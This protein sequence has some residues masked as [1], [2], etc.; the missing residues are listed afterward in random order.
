MMMFPSVNTLAAVREHKIRILGTGNGTVPTVTFGQGI[1]LSWTA[2]GRVLITWANNPGTFLGL[3][4]AGYQDA[5][6]SN[7][8]G[9]TATVGTYPNTANTFTLEIDFWGKDTAAAFDLAATT[10]LYFILE[11]S[12]LK[13]P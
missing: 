6:Q 2:T 1:T 12:E 9:C 4:G 10:S 13:K 5:T 7:V 11:F 8:A 3:A